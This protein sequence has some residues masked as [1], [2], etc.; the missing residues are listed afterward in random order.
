MASAPPGD[1]PVRGGPASSPERRV[2]SRPGLLERAVQEQLALTAWC[3]PPPP[4]GPDSLAVT[5]TGRLLQAR[6]TDEDSSSPAT[7]T[8]FAL[9]ATFERTGRSEPVAVTLRVT[10]VTPGEWVVA[11]QV[12]DP[13]PGR[14]SDRRGGRTRGSF[15]TPVPVTGWRLRRHPVASRLECRVTT[16]LP[17]LAVAARVIPGLWLLTAVAGTAL[18]LSVQQ[19]L[20]AGLRPHPSATLSVSLIALAA[21]VM[22]AKG[23]YLFLHRSRRSVQGWAV[24]GFIGG[25]VVAAVVVAAVRGVP[26]GAY[27]DTAAAGLFAGLA[28]GRLGCVFAGCCSGRPTSS[29]W[30]LWSSNQTVGTRRVPTQLLESA[31]AAVV[32][33]GSALA[34]NFA[35]AREGW[36]L[37]AAVGA[38]TAL[39]QPIVTQRDEPRQS[40]LGPWAVGVSAAAVT[41]A[42]VM[43]AVVG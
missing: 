13:S 11:A 37:V 6:D 23:W 35:G 24:Q 21:A 19:I 41:F 5:F 34:V 31:L 40:K 28:V 10:D 30:G 3:P 15:I 22:G 9:T 4:D 8:S 12:E 36:V 42:G 32:A 17:P 16:R 18:G 26:L 25:F 20:V 7:G 2:T 33:A 14:R 43:V 1:P 38:Y 27:F 29:R 39:R